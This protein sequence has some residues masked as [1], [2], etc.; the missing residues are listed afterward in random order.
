MLEY[1]RIDV[2]EGINTSKTTN[3][4]QR[5]I[6]HY[7]YFLRL[8][9]RFQPKVYDSCHNMSQKSMSFN[10]AAIVIVGRNDYRIHFCGMT[11]CK[12][13]NSMKNVGFSFKK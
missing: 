13:V 2:S 3:S 12:A 8:Y 4:W 9:F 1:G 11:K 10:N 6:Y 7:W 5:I